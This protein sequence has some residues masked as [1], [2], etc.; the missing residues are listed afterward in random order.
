MRELRIKWSSDGQRWMV[1]ACGT[2][3]LTGEPHWYN[4]TSSKCFWLAKF[5]ARLTH[6]ADARRAAIDER[7]KKRE[8]RV[9]YCAIGAGGRPCVSRKYCDSNRQ[10][11][12]SGCT[13]CGGTRQHSGNPPACGE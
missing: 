8:C 10:R 7:N 4:V 12:W 9:C 1:Q 11:K 13:G 2:Y 6:K 3:W 5:K